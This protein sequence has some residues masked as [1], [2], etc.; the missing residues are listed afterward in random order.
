MSLR[1]FWSS[2][3]CRSMSAALTR[4]RSPWEVYWLEFS[5]TS[6]I[7]LLV[8]SMEW[9]LPEVIWGLRGR[10]YLAVVHVQGEVELGEVDHGLDFGGA[11]DLS[12][13]V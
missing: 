9:K 6:S 13:E 2:S 12:V 5:S 4:R 11:G 7:W 1:S 3:A 10:G 8:R